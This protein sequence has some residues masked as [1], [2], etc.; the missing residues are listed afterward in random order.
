MIGLSFRFLRSFLTHLNNLIDLNSVTLAFINLILLIICHYCTSLHSF[1]LKK[2]S[3][4]FSVIHIILVFSLFFKCCIK[5]NCFIFIIHSLAIVFILCDYLSWSLI[6]SIMI[7]HTCLVHRNVVK[8]LVIILICLILWET[9]SC[10][11]I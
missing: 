3:Y 10:T 1:I 7:I 6:E 4:S 9:S 5:T 2:F 11:I 8:E